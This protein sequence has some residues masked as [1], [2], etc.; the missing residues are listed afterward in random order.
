MT[1]KP[2][3]WFPISAALSAINLGAVWFAAAPGE[4]LHA[5][6]HAALA[7]GFGLWAQ[8]LR[9]RR[10]VAAAADAAAAAALPA[11]GAAF[12]VLEAEMDDLRRE[13]AEA[14]ERIDFAERVLAQAPP[15]EPQ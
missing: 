1:F 3:I 10:Q 11:G 14:Q 5:T 13:L 2:S 15:R 4:P 7:L 6:T 12:E 8:R 9:Q